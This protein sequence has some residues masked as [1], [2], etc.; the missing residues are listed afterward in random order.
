ML[1]SKPSANGLASSARSVAAFA[2]GNMSTGVTSALSRKKAVSA[3]VE[4]G[5]LCRKSTRTSFFER[6]GF[7]KS[8]SAWHPNVVKMGRL[9][10][11][12][13]TLYDKEQ[14]HIFNV[15]PGVDL[16]LKQY[17]HC[18]DF[19]R[20]VSF[21]SEA[22]WRRFGLGGIGSGKALRSEDVL[23]NASSLWV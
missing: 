4:S 5:R 19:L 15:T 13:L 2:G 6:W 11:A 8:S 22:S 21:G 1:G 18:M 17:W 23:G 12:F 14:S 10:L 9:A 16:D 3:R 20:T 7:S